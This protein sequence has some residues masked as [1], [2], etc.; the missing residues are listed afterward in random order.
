MSISLKAAPVAA[1]NVCR[2]GFTKVGA[3][4]LRLIGIKQFAA[5]ARRYWPPGAILH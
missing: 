3:V 4:L 5:D 1:F 2:E